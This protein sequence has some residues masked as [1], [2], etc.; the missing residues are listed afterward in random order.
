LKRGL[1]FSKSFIQPIQPPPPFLAKITIS[2]LT[3]GSVLK[4]GDKMGDQLWCK[5]G[6]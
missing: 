1:R 6:F 3:V 4:G 5:E 2:K